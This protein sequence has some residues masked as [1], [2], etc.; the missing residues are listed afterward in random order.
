MTH[1]FVLFGCFRLF[2]I[3]VHLPLSSGNQHL[4]AAHRRVNQLLKTN[5]KVSEKTV[6]SS[7]QDTQ[8]LIRSNVGGSL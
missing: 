2:G 8:F 4:H 3:L 6:D 1:I 7:L 5:S